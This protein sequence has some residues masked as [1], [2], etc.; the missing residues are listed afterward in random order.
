[1]APALSAGMP[2]YSLTFVPVT[3]TFDGSASSKPSFVPTRYGSVG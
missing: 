1:M 3:T 2:S